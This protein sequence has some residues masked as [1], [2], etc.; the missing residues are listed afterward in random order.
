MSKLTPYDSMSKKMDH[1][2]I[3]KQAE[4]RE[5]LGWA[6][7]HDRGLPFF[8]EAVPPEDIRVESG[9]DLVDQ[10]PRGMIRKGDWK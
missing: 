2:P 9:D 10:M 5:H 1:L 7:P 4:I 6:E 3:E 8:F